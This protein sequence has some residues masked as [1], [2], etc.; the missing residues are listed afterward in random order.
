MKSGGSL[1]EEEFNGIKLKT[2][3]EEIKSY[4]LEKR[5]NM[6]D[7]EVIKN[8]KLNETRISRAWFGFKIWMNILIY[9]KSGEQKTSTP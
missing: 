2:V 6:E 4:S 8:V 7:R 3:L 5:I 9:L 1:Q